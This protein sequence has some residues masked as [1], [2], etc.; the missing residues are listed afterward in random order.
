MSL[1]EEERNSIS[2]S[3]FISE[4][5]TED[6]LLKVHGVAL[7]D[8]DVTVGAKSR[9]QKL[10][11]P[12]VLEASAQFLEGKDI[13]V[14]HENKSAYKKVGE[15]TDAKYKSGV[16]II[17]QGVVRDE[18]LE[19]KIE[20]G[21]LEVS[22]RLMHS[23]EMEE[24]GGI[25][26]PTEI[27]DF[28]NLSIVRK[29]A[30]P[31]SKI[32]PGEHPELSVDE[33]QQAFDSESEGIEE[34]HH[35]QIEKVEE[36]EAGEEPESDG[37]SEEELQSPS[38]VD[39]ARWMF[40]D[41]QSAEGAAQAFP[42]GGIHKRE[43]RGETWYLPCS[44]QS[45][46][47]EAVKEREEEELAIAEARNPDFDETETESWGDI[48][49]DTLSYYTENLDY[50]AEQ[51]DDLTQEQREEI[52][53]HTLLGDPDAD[54]ADEG[55]FFPVVNAATGDLNRGALE[56]VRSG[57]GQSADIPQ[58]TYESAFATAGRLLN[59]NF[60]TDVETNFEE[61][62]AGG[63]SGQM[64]ALASRLA[65]HT[66]LTKGEAMDFILTLSP[67][68]Y[69]DMTALAK[70]VSIPLD[71]S[72][73]TMQSVLE[74]HSMKEEETEKSVSE[75]EDAPNRSRSILNDIFG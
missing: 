28:P 9:E 72:A 57:R 4:N 27:F 16:G 65:S 18:E 10:W 14:D 52:V 66:E 32:S 75:E 35:K 1:Q 7:G 33:L 69:M 58:S 23:E 53:S 44:S 51:W 70:A 71:S 43:V 38:D 67:D 5:R 40:K 17:Y 21:W 73:D 6:G 29:G 31:S 41:R 48:P 26:A 39:Y 34:Y 36:E 46:F 47:L 45:K 2:G 22:P 3:G 8:N 56:A 24:V 59:E 20:H 68:D 25:D 62:A 63:K 11:R 54:T 74:K 37:D 60:G 13:V 19:P 55:I 15:V 61:M 42:C 64:S 30:A 49:A 12:E 50:D